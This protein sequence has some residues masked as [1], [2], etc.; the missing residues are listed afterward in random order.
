MLAF[1]TKYTMQVT[2]YSILKACSE[3]FIHWIDYGIS[4]LN[5]TPVLGNCIRPI[6]Q[7]TN[8]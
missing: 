6:E 5:V 8:T 2:S 7:Q 1:R 4:V 3:C